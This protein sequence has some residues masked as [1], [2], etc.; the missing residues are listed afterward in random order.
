MIKRLKIRLRGKG[1]IREVQF[2]VRR[3]V[4]GGYCQRD[5]E[6]VKRHIEELRKEGIP[7]PARIPVFFPVPTYMVTTASSIEVARAKTSGE[8]EYVILLDGKNIL[9]ALGSD[10][11]DRELERVSLELSKQV[12]PN[13]ISGDAWNYLDLKERWD[14]LILR[15]WVYRDGRRILYQEAALE[16][17]LPPE[18][19]IRLVSRHIPHCPLDGT[20]I[21]SGTVPILSKEVIYGERFEASLEDPIMGE[22]L[23]LEYCIDRFSWFSWERET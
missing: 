14:S 4:N 16:A 11:T 15:S 1:V 23:R 7:A 13:V 18:E 2:E 3:V 17:L 8:A 9:I 19:L 5:Q 20:L 22:E 10:H 6:L 21:F 12:C